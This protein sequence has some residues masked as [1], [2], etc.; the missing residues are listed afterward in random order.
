M[1]RLPPHREEALLSVLRRA[2]GRPFDERQACFDFAGIFAL[3]AAHKAQP[4]RGR[5]P[6]PMRVLAEIAAE[7]Y[8]AHTGKGPGRAIGHNGHLC[9]HFPAFLRALA[10]VA[11]ISIDDRVLWNACREVQRSL[12]GRADLP[13]LRGDPSD[14]R[15]AYGGERKHAREQMLG[16][17]PIGRD[18]DGVRIIEGYQPARDPE[19]NGASVFREF[20]ESN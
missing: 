20:A 3:L 8:H 12:N 19:L 4:G 7:P 16:P 9:G 17:H 5:K 2:A 6:S 13:C 1:K 15:R 14:M 11:E 18:G 10:D